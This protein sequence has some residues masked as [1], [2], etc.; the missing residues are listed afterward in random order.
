MSK[1]SYFL[2]RTLIIVLVVFFGATWWL[3]QSNLDAINN[4]KELTQKKLDSIA[5]QIEFE[6]FSKMPN[7]VGRL[8]IE[9]SIK[10]ML[11]T[12]KPPTIVTSTILST[13]QKYNNTQSSYILDESGVVRAS[14]TMDG[15]S[16]DGKNYAFR[17][18][19]KRAIKGESSAWAAVGLRS[20]LRGLYFS[21]PIFDENKIIGVAV[22]KAGLL[23][24]DEILQSSTHPLALISRDEIVFASNQNR[25]LMKSLSKLTDIER[26][27]LMDSQK[28]GHYQLE[29]LDFIFD[30]ELATRQQVEFKYFKSPISLLGWY[31]IE[32][33][34]G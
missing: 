10:K 26:L 32:F 13:V 21:A 5:Q 19:F 22:V 33:H 28:Y 9:P 29:T 16:L 17:K 23:E 6:L 20:K 4:S 8:S 1:E 3:H 15:V 12:S 2:F 11:M 31:L 27:K 14:S 25:W 18:Y 30:G 34:Q 7:I 24:L